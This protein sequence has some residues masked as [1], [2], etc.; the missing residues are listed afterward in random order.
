QVESK[1]LAAFL[2]ARFEGSEFGARTAACFLPRDALTDEVFCIKFEMEVQFVFHLSFH[3]GAVQAGT[4]PRTNAGA[5]SHISS[6]VVSRIPA[7]MSAIRFH[8][9]VSS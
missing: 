5:E 7:M 9:P 6:G 3:A 8:L 1:R 2:F 4:K